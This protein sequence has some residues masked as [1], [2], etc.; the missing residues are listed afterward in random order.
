MMGEEDVISLRYLI[1]ECYVFIFFKKPPPPP[2]SNQSATIY[3]VLYNTPMYVCMN[4]YPK[5]KNTKFFLY[6]VQNSHSP[7][8]N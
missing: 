2:S 7:N 5:K 1:I 6:L 3:F 4:R 8:H